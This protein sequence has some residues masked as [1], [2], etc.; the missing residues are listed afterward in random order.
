MECVPCQFRET[1]SLITMGPRYEPHKTLSALPILL[2]VHVSPMFEMQHERFSRLL[3]E[4]G[5]LVYGRKSNYPQHV[6]DVAVF[7]V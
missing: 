4:I 1:F 3:E 2:R 7:S 6:N 5:S